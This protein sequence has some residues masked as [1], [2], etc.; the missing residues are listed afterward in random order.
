MGKRWR[1]RERIGLREARPEARPNARSKARG[2]CQGPF[3]RPFQGSRP[4]P[5]PV[6]R[7]RGPFQGRPFRHSTN[8]VHL[9]ERDMGPCAYTCSSPLRYAKVHPHEGRGERC[10]LKTC[11][12]E[13]SGN[14]RES[15]CVYESTAES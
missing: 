1:G 5:R 3:Q 8:G 10:S 4:V 14:G 15:G 11:Q 2:P 6:P 12:S 9:G 13:V 7:P